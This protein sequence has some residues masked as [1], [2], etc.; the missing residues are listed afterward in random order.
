[1][2][3]WV[4]FINFKEQTFSEHPLRSSTK[5]CIY[6]VDLCFGGH[7]VGSVWFELL[8]FSPFSYFLSKHMD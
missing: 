7:R 4:I 6:D 8:N 3:Y 1:V 2:V 5:K